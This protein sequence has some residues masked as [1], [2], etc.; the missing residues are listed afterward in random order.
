MIKKTLLMFWI[1][2]SLLPFLAL[3]AEKICPKCQFKNEDSDRYCLHCQFEIQSLSEEEKKSMEVLNLQRAEKTRD[4]LQQEAQKQKERKKE[5][6]PANTP[7]VQPPLSSLEN[8]SLS[9]DGK[10]IKLGMTKQKIRNMLNL[11]KKLNDDIWDI[12]SGKGLQNSCLYF[13]DDV[14]VKWEKFIYY[15][16]FIQRNYPLDPQVLKIGMSEQELKSLW[17]N[18]DCK[19]ERGSSVDYQVKVSYYLKEPDTETKYVRMKGKGYENR[20][21]VKEGPLAEIL[22]DFQKKILNIRL[23]EGELREAGISGMDSGF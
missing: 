9:I 14:L 7:L 2:F 11:H 16:Y 1:Y 17:G 3:F 15:D 5:E 18:P 8:I 10:L 19:Y 12:S 13:A 21:I 23:R 6:S 4:T 20:R 22:F